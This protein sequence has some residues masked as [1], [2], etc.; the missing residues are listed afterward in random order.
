MVQLLKVHKTVQ[1][2]EV[3]QLELKDLKMVQQMLLNQEEDLK[4][5]NVTQQLIQIVL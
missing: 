5:K 4:V 1:P 3:H 2:L